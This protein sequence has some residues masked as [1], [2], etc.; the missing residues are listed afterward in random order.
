MYILPKYKESSRLLAKGDH[1]LSVWEMLRAGAVLSGVAHTQQVPGL[2]C[3]ELD[4][5]FLVR[6]E[7][8]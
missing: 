2:S 6:C 3:S 4:T 7:H 8:R 5:V 1:Q